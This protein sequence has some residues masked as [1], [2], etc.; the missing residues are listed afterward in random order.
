MPVACEVQA[1]CVYSDISN[2]NIEHQMLL[3]HIQWGCDAGRW[4]KVLFITSLQLGRESPA[5]ETVSCV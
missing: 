5:P 4:R 3:A 2:K 1:I